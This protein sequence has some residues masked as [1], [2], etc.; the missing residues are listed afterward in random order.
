MKT[1][2]LDIKDFNKGC[3]LGEFGDLQEVDTDLYNYVEVN[4]DGDRV[5]IWGIKNESAELWDDNGTA[6]TEFLEDYA[7]EKEGA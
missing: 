5:T 7:F 2:K 4:I 1:Y 6:D 3:N